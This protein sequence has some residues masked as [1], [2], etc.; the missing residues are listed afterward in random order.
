MAW[1]Y[2]NDSKEKIGPLTSRELKQ[3]VLEGTVV[4]ETF[5]E[6]PNGR[7]GLAKDVKGLKFPEPPPEQTPP[8]ADDLYIA[9]PVP[10]I[11]TSPQA[12]P[13]PLPTANLF[14]TNCG[15]SI[16]AQAVACMSCGARPAGH[17][18][19]CRQCGVALNP[20]QVVCIKC[21]TG[22]TG[23]IGMGGTMANIMSAF[24]STGGAGAPSHALSRK[25]NIYF[26]VFWICMAGGVAMMVLPSIL[27]GALA[28]AKPSPDAE[29]SAGG[30]AMFSAAM[31]I[32]MIAYPLV[33]VGTVFMYML[34][35]QLWKLVPRDLARTTPGKAVGLCF[36]PL[37]NFYWG[38]VAFKGLG[39]DMNKMLQRHGTHYQVNG[40]LGLTTSILWLVNWI[41]VCLA[42]H[43]ITAILGGLVSLAYLVVSIFFFNSAKNGAIALLE[44]GG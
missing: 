14:C 26:M 3:L 40:V 34:L 37:F 8:E 2:F 7:T 41:M 12:A 21:G 5:V 18:K 1:H 29:L 22:L 28:A 23:G 13:A 20:E 38:F 19:F 24:Q 30:G 25:L 43:P 36:I 17:K 15:N 27:L 16:G 4:R 44:Q 6:D 39:E 11:P 32:M 35:Y 42:G 10:I 31:L 33:I 9:T